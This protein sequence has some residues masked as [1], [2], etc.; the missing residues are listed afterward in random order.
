MKH[1]LFTILMTASLAAQAGD[2]ALT[3]E[4]DRVGRELKSIIVAARQSAGVK[5]MRQAAD[6][7]T[8]EHDEAVKAIPGV[9]ALDARIAAA[10]EQLRALQRERSI[11]LGRHEA[12][13][14]PKREAR[15]AARRAYLYAAQGG[16]RGRE[17]AARRNELFRQREGTAVP[18]V[19]PTR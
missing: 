2:E 12:A 4:I 14:Q 10:Q 7:A 6:E 3:A 16:D 19:L 8:T 15:D 5:A 18:P 9:Q 11:L 13:I 1:L 17:L